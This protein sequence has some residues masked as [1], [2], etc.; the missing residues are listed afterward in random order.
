MHLHKEQNKRALFLDRDGVLNRELGRYVTSVDEFEVLPT[1][2]QALKLAA[3]AGFMLII[4]SN[5]GGVAKGLYGMDE[6]YAMQAKLNGVLS[7]V[8]VHITEGYYCPHHPEHGR[9][10]CRKPESLLLE[11]AMARFSIDSALSFMIGDHS[12]DVHAA[13]KVRVKGILMEQNSS[14]LDVV[15]ELI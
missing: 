11:K 3:D 12:R 13:E 6:V 4:V 8:G 5:Q 10:L 1:V 14:L 15:M 7:D 9:C 2:S